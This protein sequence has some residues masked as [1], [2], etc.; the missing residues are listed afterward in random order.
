[1]DATEGIGAEVVLGEPVR[2]AAGAYLSE[3]NRRVTFR[4][5]SL[6]EASR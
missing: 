3:L 2:R 4:V 6:N 1:M 5:V